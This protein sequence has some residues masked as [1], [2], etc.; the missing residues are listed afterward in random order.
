VP[1]TVL[2]VQVD[3]PVL[4]GYASIRGFAGTA[5]NNGVPLPLDGSSTL[6]M[7]ASAPTDWYVIQAEADLDNITGFNNDTVVYG[8]SITNQIFVVREG[9]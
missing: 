3:G 2:P 8:L 1:W 5:V 7:P 9:Q 4:F 6:T